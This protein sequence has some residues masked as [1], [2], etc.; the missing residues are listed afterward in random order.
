MDEKRP[1]PV[2]KLGLMRERRFPLPALVLNHND[3]FIKDDPVAAE[4]AME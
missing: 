2:G 3:G 4:D 1:H